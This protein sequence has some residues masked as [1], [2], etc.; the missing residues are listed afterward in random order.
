MRKALLLV[1]LLLPMLVVMA[2]NKT[3]TGRITDE[4]GNPLAGVSVSAKGSRVGTSTNQN[5]M[6]SLSVPTN[7]RSLVFTSVGYQAREMDI[8]SDN[9]ANARLEIG[10]TESEN[11]V[12]TGYTRER[13]SKYAGSAAKVTSE[14]INQVPMASIDQILQGR[15][16][17]LWSVAGS[18]QPGAAATVLI[19]G[20]GSI[21]GV[22]APLYVMDGIPIEGGTFQSLNPSDIESVDVLKDAVSTALYGSRGANGVIVIT[23]KRGK[24]GKPVFSLKSQAGFANRTTPKFEMMNAEER[25]QFEKEVG[26]EFG[27]TI[28]PGWYLSRDNPRNA[29][30]SATDLNEMDRR[31]D[32]LRNTKVDWVDLFFRTGTFQEHELSASGGNDKVKFYTSLNYYKQEGI[33]RRSDMERYTFRGN[34]DF[35]S[36]RFSASISSGIGFTKRSFIESENTTAITNPFS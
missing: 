28:G 29:G 20:A 36:N 30:F 4:S 16:P 34:L 31:L 33:A 23:T 15:A 1:V 11:V 7:T 26:Q 9:T 10:V 2:Q 32:S 17:G 14:K 8:A 18:G 12:V 5:G 6:F 21:N 25:L 19:R 24:A 22:T 3:V 13:A 35:S 27:L